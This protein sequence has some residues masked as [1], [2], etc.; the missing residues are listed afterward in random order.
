MSK[1]STSRKRASERSA[2]NPQQNRIWLF[3]GVAALAVL[4]TVAFIVISIPRSPGANS[5]AYADIPQETVEVGQVSG[6]ALGNA[7]APVTLMEFADF[8]CPH[9]YNVSPAIHQIIEKYVTAGTVRIIYVPVTFVNPPTSIPAAKA[10]YCA[11]GQGRAWEMHDE[12]WSRYLTPGPTS[13]RET[14]LT[15][16]AKNKLGLDG[17]EFSECFNADET[18]AEIERQLFEARERGVEST[19]TIFINDQIVTYPTEDAAYEALTK[20]IDSILNGQE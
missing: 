17:N 2:P 19:P 3:V 8:S 15:G 11:A 14:I 20:R 9:C 16:I 4:A 12:I 7:D 6:F 13:Y 1:T 18:D 10:M 5:S